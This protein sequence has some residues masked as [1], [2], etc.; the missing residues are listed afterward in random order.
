MCRPSVTD[1]DQLSVN[2]DW[3]TVR[4]QSFGYKFNPAF[5]ATGTRHQ[6]AII[7][8]LATPL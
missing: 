7:A 8:V 2:V 4:S 5:L 3:K 6:T 1:R